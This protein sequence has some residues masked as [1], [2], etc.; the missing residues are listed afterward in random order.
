MKTK[1]NNSV[2]PSEISLFNV[3]LKYIL[4]ILLV[5][6]KL[7]ALDIV[8]P[9]YNMKSFT[10]ENGMKVYMVSNKESVN[11]QISVEVNVGMAIENNENAG[12]SHLLEHLIFRDER[13]PKNKYVYYLHEEG[14][15]YVN[16]FTSQYLT[17]YIA[18]IASEKSYWLVNTF[19]NMIF[20]KNINENDLKVEKGALQVEVGDIKWYHTL[21]N[22][23]YSF[24]NW[25]SDIFPSIIDMYKES[26]SFEKEHSLPIDFYFIKNNQKFTLQQL[27]DHYD[28]YYYPSNMVLKIVGNFDEQIMKE[29]IYNS[30]GAVQKNR[31]IKQ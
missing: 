29:T 25:V 10:L 8:D 18:T 27:L 17:E 31:T 3:D 6:L 19:N 9:Y 4:L 21:L 11:T 1:L 14:A 22:Y 30:F 15:T 23:V 28:S 7:F 24:V 20:D 26:F 5:S 12:I 13:V 2:M 16:G